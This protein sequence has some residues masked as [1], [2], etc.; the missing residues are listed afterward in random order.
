MTDKIRIACAT[1][2]GK[3]L[4]KEHFGDASLFMIYEMDVDTGSY[5]FIE[6]IENRSPEEKK[7]GDP[8]KAKSISEILDGPQVLLAYAMGTN[9]VR[10]RKKFCPVISREVDIEKA[11][12][13]LKGKLDLLS[14]EVKKEKGVDR[15]II[16]I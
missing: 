2:D 1:D 13:E 15:E 4:I 9:I 3:N 12:E 5:E 7:H 6:R 8:A 16:R 10:I 14:V 11:L